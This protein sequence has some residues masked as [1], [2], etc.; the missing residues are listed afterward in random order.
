MTQKDTIN[1]AYGNIPKDIPS[2]FDFDILEDWYRVMRY[3]WIR[4]RRFF[5]R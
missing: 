2:P 5:T 1:K 4:L 3:R